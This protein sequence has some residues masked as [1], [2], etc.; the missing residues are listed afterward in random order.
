VQGILALPAFRAAK[1][2]AMPLTAIF[3]LKEAL[4]I[5]AA[6]II[7]LGTMEVAP[8]FSRGHEG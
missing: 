8:K 1:S 5:F 4:L 6:Y 7:V 2:W 3:Q